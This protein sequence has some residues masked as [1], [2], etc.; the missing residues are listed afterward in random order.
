MERRLFL[1]QL[2]LVSGL[3]SLAAK[4]QF[5]AALTDD[6]YSL[7]QSWNPFCEKLNAGIFDVKLWEK[8]KKDLRALGVCK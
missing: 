7:Q 3:V 5:S 1:Q 6:W 8:V 2:S 4:P